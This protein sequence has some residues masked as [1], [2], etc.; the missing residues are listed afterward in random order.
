MAQAATATEQK[1]QYENSYHPC[2]GA[3]RRQGTPDEDAGSGMVRF[4]ASDANGLMHGKLLMISD[5]RHELI[6]QRMSV[7]GL[8]LTVDAGRSCRAYR[9]IKD[10]FSISQQRPVA[11]YDSGLFERMR[12]ARIHLIRRLPIVEINAEPDAYRRVVIWISSV[13]AKSAIW[14][15]WLASVL[16]AEVKTGSKAIR[17]ASPLQSMAMVDCSAM[18]ATRLISRS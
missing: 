7:D 17:I 11:F 14:L 16:G 9:E 13:L 5:Q 12:D 8:Q 6:R 2:N 15:M 10:A 18:A 1:T 3:M 4:S